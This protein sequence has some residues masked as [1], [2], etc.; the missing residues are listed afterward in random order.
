MSKN[1]HIHTLRDGTIGSSALDMSGDFT[2]EPTNILYMDNASLICTWTGTSPVGA[3]SVQ[4]SN[5]S[6]NPPTKW[7][8]LTLDGT[9]TV[10]GNSD[11][12]SI[13]LNQL[14]F[15]WIRTVYTRASG[16]GTM[17]IDMTT[18]RLA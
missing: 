12:G 2:T 11:N 8:T 16:T 5:D 3:I 14:S 17:T 6:S 7:E 1:A 4:V 18:K 10:T 13:N 9:A 15:A